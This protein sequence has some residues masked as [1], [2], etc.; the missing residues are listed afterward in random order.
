MASVAFIT[1]GCKVN[2]TETDAMAGLFRHQGYEV[3]EPDERADVETGRF[4][5]SVNRAQRQAA[6]NAL[7]VKSCPE[8]PESELRASTARSVRLPQR[9][10]A[11]ASGDNFCFN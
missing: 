9:Q 1:L 6:R 3:V 10:A 11:A 7:L 2:Q 5:S 4:T 8:K